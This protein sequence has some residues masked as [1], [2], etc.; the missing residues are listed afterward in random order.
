VIKIAAQTEE[1]F[2]RRPAPGSGNRLGGGWRSRCLFR[3]GAV[4]MK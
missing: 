1:L 2:Y 3:G 4:L